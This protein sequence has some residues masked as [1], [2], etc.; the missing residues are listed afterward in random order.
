MSQ[1]FLPSHLL[2]SGSVTAPI[3]EA[4]NAL[5]KK[6][7]GY[8]NAVRGQRSFPPR[9]ELTLRGMAAFLPYA[10]IVRF[11]EGGADYE[12]AYVGDAQRQ[13]FDSYFKGLRISELEATAPALG[14]VLRGVYDTIRVNGRPFLV[15]GRTSV[16]PENSKEAYYESAFLPLG[17]DAVD[18][19]LIVGVRVPKPYWDI[20]D[21]KLTV[22]K[23]QT[24]G[25]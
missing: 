9:K 16:D 15:R 2:A 20:P 6:S 25:R 24:R 3:A 10:L 12:F 4:G 7:I 19:I 8:W 23:E 17:V 13:M 11:L 14:K 5:V 22:L 18:H 1:S 21:D